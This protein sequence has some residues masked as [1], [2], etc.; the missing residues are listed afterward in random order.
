MAITTSYSWELGSS[1]LL[2][3]VSSAGS[4]FGPAVAGNLAGDRYLAAW[5]DPNS[6]FQVE[7]RIVDG[8]QTP[9]GGEFTVNDV[10]PNLATVQLDPGV[11]GLTNG[12]FVV[13]YTDYASDPGGD[14]RAR[15]YD[16]SGT[17]LGSDFEIVGSNLFGDAESSVAALAGGGF[18]VSY[19]R[20]AG[21]LGVRA[22]VFD[23][24]G[25]FSTAVIA[26][27]GSGQGASSVAGLD[28][29]GFVVAWQDDIAGAVYFRRFQSDGTEL[30][31]D[32]VLIDMWW[33]WPT[34]ASRWP[35]RTA[36]GRSMAPRSPSAS[37]TRTAPPEPTS[38]APTMRH[39]A[40]SRPATR[41]SRPSPPW[42]T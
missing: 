9:L 38:S 39:S 23:Q 14:I 33:R 15:L 5:S 18:V 2:N 1:L 22:R 10:V 12:N 13:T 35:T 34:A 29:G 19:T 20:N 40:A 30:D 7:G 11:A 41:N 32:R 26:D 16:S 8:E 36:A 31:T 28:S 4:Q 42:A 27:A 17:V 24:D 21:N 6:S 37:S 3:D 25:N